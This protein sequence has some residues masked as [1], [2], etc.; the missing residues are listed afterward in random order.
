M[1]SKKKDTADQLTLRTMRAAAIDRFGGPEVLSIHNLPV[2][3]PEAGEVLIALHTV[4]AAHPAV[5]EGDSVHSYSF[6]NPKGGF[7]A[8]YVALSAENVAPIPK[9]IDLEHAGA[10]PTTGL[11]AIQA[12][13][14]L[15]ASSEASLSLFTGRP[16]AW[17]VSLS[18]LRSCAVRVSSPLR[19]VRTA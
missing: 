6:L 3:V 14:T 15:W 9:S 5:P 4:G 2:P 10:I 12:S 11:T 7:Y 8:E 17:E 18:S 16:A 13:M 19:L 1:P